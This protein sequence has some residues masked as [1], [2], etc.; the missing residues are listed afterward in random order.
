M[1][2]WIQKRPLGIASI[3]IFSSHII[4][5]TKTHFWRRLRGRQKC[6]WRTIPNSLSY[7]CC[8]THG[9]W[10]TGGRDQTLTS[11]ALL[12]G[13]VYFRKHFNQTNEQAQEKLYILFKKYLR[14]RRTL[15]WQPYRRNV[16]CVQWD[17]QH[18]YSGSYRMM[19]T[20]SSNVLTVTWQSAS[21]SDD[22]PPLKMLYTVYQI[23]RPQRDG[24]WMVNKNLKG[25]CC[26]LI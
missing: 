2:E 19:K 1:N 12:C 20:E 11:P 25:V 10:R 26:G 21:L 4:N 17:I 7:I 5:N 22:D 23:S 3:R 9:Y 16:P 18:D 15:R 24:P 14:V 6:L 13:A 8:W